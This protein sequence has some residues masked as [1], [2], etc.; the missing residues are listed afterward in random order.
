[1]QHLLGNVMPV[2]ELRMETG[3]SGCP[4]LPLQLSGSELLSCGTFA[5]HGGATNICILCLGIL[6]PSSFSSQCVKTPPPPQRT[7]AEKTA[8]QLVF[9]F[10]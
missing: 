6:A 1:M 3:N 8:N 5:G 10:R 2:T 9:W 7:A 4:Q